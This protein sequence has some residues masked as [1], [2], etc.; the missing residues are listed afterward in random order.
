MQRSAVGHD[1][2]PGGLRV[3]QLRRRLLQVGRHRRV[4]PKHK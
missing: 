1:A 4:G 3:A 2:L